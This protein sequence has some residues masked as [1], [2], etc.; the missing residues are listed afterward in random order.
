MHEVKDALPDNLTEII[1]AVVTLVTA[2]W[3]AFKRGRAV[4]RQSK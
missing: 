4:G 2:I 1:G 3:A